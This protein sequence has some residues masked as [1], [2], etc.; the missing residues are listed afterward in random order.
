MLIFHAIHNIQKKGKS[1]IDYI[2]RLVF[3]QDTRLVLFLYPRPRQDQDKTKTRKTFWNSCM[4]KTKN[5]TGGAKN[6]VLARL[7]SV[8]FLGLTRK[9]KTIFLSLNN[10][11]LSW[12]G[13]LFLICRYLWQKFS[14]FFFI[15]LNNFQMF[16]LNLIS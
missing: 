10:K 13:T 15:I 9:T 7:R 12:I 3:H 4:T 16:I 11:F 14:D 8:L 5:K 1:I 2:Y 6:L